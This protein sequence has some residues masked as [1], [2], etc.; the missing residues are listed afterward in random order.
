MRERNLSKKPSKTQNA[1]HFFG[2]TGKKSS[3]FFSSEPVQAKLSIGQPGD[4]FE[5][6]AD[7]V[8]DRVVSGQSA[9]PVLSTSGGLNRKC[10]ECDQEDKVQRAVQEEEE[11]VQ[12]K[13]GEEEEIQMQAE[14]E[15]EAVQTKED[16]EDVQMKGEEEEEAVQA[17]E[18]EEEE[19]QTKSSGPAAPGHSFTN[20]LHARKGSGSN[21]SGPIRAKMESSIGADF[22]NVRVHTDREA[23]QM[24]SSIH[25]QAFT[26]GNDVYFNAGKY[27]P[28]S[29]EGQRLL[30][31]ELTHVVQQ[32]A[33]PSG[34]IVQRTLGDGHDLTNPR[35][36][37]ETKLEQAFDNEVVIKNFTEGEHVR[38]IQQAL[39]DDGIPLPAFGADGKFGSETKTGLITYQNRYSLGIDGEVGP[40]TM[41]HMDTHFVSPAPTPPV[42]APPGP[43]P[44]GSV[45]IGGDSTLWWF[46]RQSPAGYKTSET[47]T[48]TASGPGTFLWTVTSG[49]TKA[50]FG[51]LPFATGP[52]VNIR[53]KKPSA[54][55]ED[56]IVKVMFTSATGGV[57]VASKKVTVKAPNSLGFLRNVD[58]TDP[59]FVYR[60][61][62]HYSIKDQ[63]GTI[64]PSVVPINEKFTAP[65]SSDFPF[66]N[67]RRGAEGGATVSP[68]DWFD[69]VQ[70]EIPSKFPSPVGP[71]ALTR[72]VPIYHWPGDWRIGSTSIGV[73]R[74]VATVT[75]QK[76]RGFAR[77]T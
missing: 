66:M 69:H 31:H 40:E 56:V 28:E 7:A 54:A 33:A 47:L 43:T 30:A 21:L 45:S 16:E 75:W 41:G 12:A 1:Q 6:E 77:H 67:W 5:K 14:E 39:I 42:P 13:E 62:I 17:K 72:F 8:A 10:A 73:G 64:L 19:M 44:G 76:N 58:K 23:N 35:F 22:S 25:A 37:G 15:E 55:K 74:K 70:G 29:T 51:G 50:D 59:T 53:S 52:S 38:K 9:T 27:R 68:T 26:R 20:R 49:F 2:V 32:G 46:D 65:P 24:S 11:A 71:T 4:K 3:N 60:T 34:K 57:S 63:F 36:A 48:A 61:E 18:G